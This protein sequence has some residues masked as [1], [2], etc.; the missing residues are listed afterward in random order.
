[1]TEPT[2]TNTLS[3]AGTNSM[4][5]GQPMMNEPT[6]QSA[7]RWSGLPWSMRLWIWSLLVLPILTTLGSWGLIGLTVVV[8]YF[9]REKAQPSVATILIMVVGIIIFTL[10]IMVVGT[11][12]RS[13]RRMLLDLA[14]IRM[15]EASFQSG[16]PQAKH[17][18]AIERWTAQHLKLFTETADTN[19]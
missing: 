19:A 14:R 1:M 13:T 8:L 6:R 7:S 18:N 17:N 9:D 2:T 3:T 15:V 16:L 11:T 10:N 12:L 4:S 5:S